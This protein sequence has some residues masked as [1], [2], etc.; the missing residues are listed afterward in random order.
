MEGVLVLSQ[1]E[2]T[3]GLIWLLHCLAWGTQVNAYNG[4][5][6]DAALDV[7]F[8]AIGTTIL[9]YVA[10]ALLLWVISRRSSTSSK[11]PDQTNRA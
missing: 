1:K 4:H 5:F 9:H 2:V 11:Q 3:W 8:A 7:T 10:W 6:I